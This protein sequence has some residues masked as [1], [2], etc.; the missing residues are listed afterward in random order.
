MASNRALVTIIWEEKNTEAG[1]AVRSY[2]LP[3]PTTYSGTTT[4]LVDGGM[5]VSGH[6][7]SSVV[8]SDVAQISLSW[9]YLETGEWSKINQLFKDRYINTVWFYD[10]TTGD[11]EKR[12]MYI[13]D[14]S[15]GLWRRDGNGNVLGWTDCSLQFTEV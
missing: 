8:R 12:E 2:P 6:L 7:L 5:S 14:R 10:Q 15:A 13:S 4:T 3:E 11:W 9:S 1:E